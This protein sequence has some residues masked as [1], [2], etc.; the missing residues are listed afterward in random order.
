MVSQKPGFLS[1]NAGLRDAPRP[2]VR[3]QSIQPTVSPNP[4][5]LMS[6]RHLTLLLVAIASFAVSACGTASTA[7]RRDCDIVTSGSSGRC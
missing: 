1:Q 6:R 7:P 5:L 3:R 2:Y 4:E